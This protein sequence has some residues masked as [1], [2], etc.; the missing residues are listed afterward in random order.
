MEFPRAVLDPLVFV[1]VFINDLPEALK[2]SSEVFLYADNTNV[3]RKIQGIEDGAKLKEDLD[4]LRQ[5]T[6]R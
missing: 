5:W 2:N 4:E 6:G 1:Q 3:Y